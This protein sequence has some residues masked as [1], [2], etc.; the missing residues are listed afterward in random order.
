MS[1][2]KSRPPVSGSSLSQ[3]LNA[4]EGMVNGIT[5]GDRSVD[6]W[7]TTVGGRRLTLALILQSGRFYNGQ[8]GSGNIEKVES[9][10]LTLVERRSTMR[11][12]YLQEGEECQEFLRAHQQN[13]TRNSRSRRDFSRTRTPVDKCH[14]RLLALAYDV[15]LISATV[16]QNQPLI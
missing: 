9:G 1:P 5:R 4:F 3:L 10:S 13:H 2:T 15:S 6:R 16:E 12:Q 7:V 11:Y 8:T 14:R